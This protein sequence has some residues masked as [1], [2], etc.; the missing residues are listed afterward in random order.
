[1]YLYYLIF[2]SFY[3]EKIKFCAAPTLLPPRPPEAP[4]LNAPSC[5]SLVFCCLLRLQFQTVTVEFPFW[6]TRIFVLQNYTL[7]HKSSFYFYESINYSFFTLS[8]AYYFLFLLSSS[9]FNIFFLVLTSVFYVRDF[10]KQLVI[11]GCYSIYKIGM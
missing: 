10:F 7:I 8:F 3:K 9:L 4:A 1:M 6:Q 11:L 2:H 5:L